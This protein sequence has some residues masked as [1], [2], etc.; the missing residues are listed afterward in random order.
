VEPV[1]GVMEMG[2]EAAAVAATTKRECEAEAQEA[3]RKKAAGVVRTRKPDISRVMRSF[4]RVDE[5]RLKRGVARLNKENPDAPPIVLEELTKE[6]RA[7][8]LQQEKEWARKK[9]E[10]DRVQREADRL[11][12]EAERAQAPPAP[13]EDPSKDKWQLDYDFERQHLEMKL[14]RETGFSGFAFEDN[15]K[16][17]LND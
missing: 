1:T 17:Y 6:E 14:A 9:E 12:K 8:L 5:L 16:G 11:A 7:A 4:D 2:S 10:V 15:S 3:G 13:P